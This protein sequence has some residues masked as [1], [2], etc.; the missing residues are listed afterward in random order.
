[1]IE[2]NVDEFT[3]E[4]DL[5]V[6]KYETRMVEMVQ[7]FAYKAILFKAVDLTPFGDLNDIT[8]RYYNDKRRLRYLP[9][10]PGTAK[11]G[12]VVS[13]N[14]RDDE[15][16]PGRADSGGTNIKSKGKRKLKEFKLGDMIFIQNNVPYMTQSGFVDD[17]Y[18]SIEGGYSKNKAPLGVGKPTMDHILSVYKNNIKLNM[19]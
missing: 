11:G 2:L 18:G 13:M 7:D 9:P 4:F 14:T 10:V 1:M 8:E 17:S 16:F 6:E 12:W 5:L 3:K 19:K 15:L